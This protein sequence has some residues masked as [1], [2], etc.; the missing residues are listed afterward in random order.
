MSSLI[1][2][3]F[4]RHGRSLADDEGKYESRYDA[5]LTHVGRAQI[6]ARADGWLKAGVQ[7]DLVIASSLRRAHE[8]AQIVALTLG[9]PIEL[10]PD[11]M[12]VDTGKLAGLTY[13]EGNRLYPRPAFRSPFEAI[14]ETGESEYRIHS[15]AA[16]ALER[17]IRREP[18]RYLVVAHGGIINA[19][20]R[21]ICGS[22]A[23][24][25]DAGIWFSFGD[26]G[27]ARL[28]YDRDCHHWSFKELGFPPAIG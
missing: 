2:I 23:P 27:C 11:W 1:S 19:A 16:L 28:V 24:L 7:F 21:V 8:S 4:L 10:D 5:P 12:E 9:V 17:V 3:T 13:E 26:A 15:R 6:Q 14:A 25:N 20:L 18:G 22:P